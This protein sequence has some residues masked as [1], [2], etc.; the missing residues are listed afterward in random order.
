MS[1]LFVVWFIKDVSSDEV[2]CNNATLTTTNIYGTN[3][4]IIVLFKRNVYNSFQFDIPSTQTHLLVCWSN[5]KDQPAV[6]I[7]ASVQLSQWQY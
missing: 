4:D 3:T 5:L 6:S 2:G 7:E 1:C